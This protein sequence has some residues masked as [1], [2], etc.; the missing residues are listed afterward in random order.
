ML[1]QLYGYEIKDGI[2]R[3]Q[4][5]EAKIIRS[6]FHDVIDGKTVTA[7]ANNLNEQGIETRKK[8]AKWYHGMISR[9][10]RNR[11]YCGELGYPKIVNVSIQNEAISILNN[12]NLRKRRLNSSKRNKESPFYKMIHCEN[13]GSN[14][15]LYEGKEMFYWRCTADIRTGGC[16]LYHRND[17]IKDEDMHGVVLEAINDLISSPQLIMNLGSMQPNHLEIVKIDNEIRKLLQTDKEEMT[18]IEKLLKD[19][20]QLSYAQYD[21]D[22]ISE[23]MI[24][25]AKV[26]KLYHQTVITRDLVKSLIKEILIDENGKVTIVFINHQCI[27]KQ[28]S[29]IR[30]IPHG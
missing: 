27:E 19:K 17:G 15:W 30:G 14:F 25:E 26:S 3:V 24:L 18:M 12:R 16:G 23:T 22:Y 20:Y 21:A 1:D 2:Y 7:I 8:D 10:I 4:K 29:I 13:C 6:M 11:R 9:I 5:K 28:A